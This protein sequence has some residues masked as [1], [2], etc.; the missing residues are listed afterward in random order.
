ML[1]SSLSRYLILPSFLFN[2]S[3][4]A[5][6]SVSCFLALSW[7][8]LLNSMSFFLCFSKDMIHRIRCLTSRFLVD[9]RLPQSGMPH[10]CSS[11]VNCSSSR[12]ISSTS[13]ILPPGGRPQ[14]ST[15]FKLISSK[16]PLNINKDMRSLAMEYKISN[17]LTEAL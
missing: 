15:L 13:L 12:S 10:D 11:I 14:S 1:N 6:V 2:L 9:L 17:Y 3:I 7:R 8:L 16:F 5:S 4:N